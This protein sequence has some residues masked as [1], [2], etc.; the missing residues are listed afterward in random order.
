M[1]LLQTE[2]ITNATVFPWPRPPSSVT[3][4]TPQWVTNGLHWSPPEAANYSKEGS[5]SYF[6]LTPVP[7]I[8]QAAR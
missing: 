7:S 6:I 4:L 2:L 8:Q 3:A 5:W 1:S